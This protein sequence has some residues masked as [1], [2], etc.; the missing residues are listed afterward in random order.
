[1]VSNLIR[2]RFETREEWLEGRGEGIGA[3]DAA[4]VVGMS[5][6]KSSLALWRE[7]V[8]K[9]A[10][11]DLSG[12]SAVEQGNRLEPALRTLFAAMHPELAVEYHQFDILSQAERP[13][14]FA[15]LDGELT[16]GEGR[17]GILEIKTSTPTNA[18]HWKDWDGQIPRHYYLQ[19]LWQL[20]STGWDYVFLFA[21]LFNRDGDATVRTYKFERADCERDLDWLLPK[22]EVFWK[23]ITDGTMP[24][25]TL[26]L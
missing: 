20:L 18:A 9:A 14:L 4:A 15:T 10:P 1:M 16:D 25:Q 13:W 17:R 12:S 3:S 7:K 26:I 24:S 22:A 2:R 21:C 8:G 19:I 11:K 5:P 23:H 6:W